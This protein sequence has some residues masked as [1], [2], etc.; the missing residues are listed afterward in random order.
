MFLSVEP[1]IIHAEEIRGEQLTQATALHSNC[2][3]GPLKDAKTREECLTERF[4]QIHMLSSIAFRA[5]VEEGKMASLLVC[6][7]PLNQAIK[8]NITMEILTS[9]TLT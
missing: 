4:T 6:W 5:A 1:Q 8:V 2:G 7:K 3:P 9:R